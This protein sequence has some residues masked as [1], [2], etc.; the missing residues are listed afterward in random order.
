MSTLERNLLTGLRVTIGWAF[1]YAGLT[2]FADPSW[3]AAGFLT[4]TTTFHPLFAPFAAPTILPLTNFLVK[5]GHLL[6]GLSLVTGSLTR[7]GAL[8]GTVLMLA[9]WLAHMN[10]PY[11]ET[12][13][14]FLIDFH[15]VY[16]IGLVYLLTKP[17]AMLFGIDQWLASLKPVKSNP[18]LRPLVL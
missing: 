3:S 16:A 8:F 10:F 4:H 9:Y 1:L 2:Q 17:P 12:K 11:V 14:N 18:L 7:V 5:W 13:L 15:V 6:I